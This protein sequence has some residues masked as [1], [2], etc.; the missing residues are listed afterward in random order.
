MDTN[1][2]QRF[3]DERIVKFSLRELIHHLQA[4]VATECVVDRC[5]AQFDKIID[6]LIA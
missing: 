2:F 1:G 4:T 3:G 6:L 5:K